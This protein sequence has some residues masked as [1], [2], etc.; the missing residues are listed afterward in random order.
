MSRELVEFRA[1]PMSHLW[2]LRRIWING[3]WKFC[4]YKNYL[5][6]ENKD[7]NLM[8]SLK[9]P[10]EIVARGTYANTAF[11]RKFR[12]FHKSALCWKLSKG[13]DTELIWSL[14]SLLGSGYRI[15]CA[16]ACIFLY[17][18]WHQEYN[19]Q[20]HSVLLWTL[21]WWSFY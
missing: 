21:F 1:H 10:A 9:P 4:S 12:K 6:E 19:D 14:D 7:S 11:S 16:F 13:I 8:N 18:I 2:F 5:N 3:Y 17:S 15:I 20:K